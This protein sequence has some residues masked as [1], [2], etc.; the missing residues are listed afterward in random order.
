MIEKAKSIVLGVLVVLSLVQSYFLM[1][2]P[3]SLG[4]TVSSDQDYVNTEPMGK[5]LSVEDVIFPD[6]LVLHFGGNEHTVLYPG[7][8]FYEM[9]LNERIQGREFKGFQR[10]SA[11]VLDWDEIR[12]NDMGVEL[13]FEAG[14]SVELL[15][16][17]LKLK[18]DLLFLGDSIDR[19]LIFKTEDSEEVRT[20][21]FSV[22][23]ESVY[24]SVQADLTVRDVQDYVGFGQYQSRY[25]LTSD[26]LYVPE[27]PIRAVQMTYAYETFSP[28]LMRRNLFF[29]PSTTRAVEGRNGAQIYTDGKRGLQVEQSG[30]WISYTD[31]AAPQSAENVL[32]D[33]FYAAVEFVNQHGGWD[34]SYRYSSAA[35]GLD[36][37]VIQFQQYMNNY[38]VLTADSSR[39]GYMQLSL[40]QG[41]VTEYNRSL[42]TL[43]DEAEERTSRWLAGGT[44]LENALQSYDRREEVIALYPAVQA[45]KTEQKEGTRMSFVPVWAVRLA[46]GT[47]HTLL[48]AYPAGYTPPETETEQDEDGG[49]GTETG[50]LPPN[51]SY[52]AD[53]GGGGNNAG[54]NDT[55]DDLSSEVSGY[56]LG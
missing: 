22:D 21:F 35:S 2:S 48:E 17:L 15:Q 10:S 44:E 45:V 4:A 16:K 37:T 41:A 43:A 56:G 29:D 20:F 36:G 47:Q 23:G 7:S 3:P 38:P 32:S 1:Y 9:I 49:T 24:E 13:H 40:Q 55:N 19:V 52:G 5:E 12:K 6:E 39:Y 18:G 11:D 46:D 27:K 33:N 51:S 14:V 8:T 30:T 25:K 50:A 26:G 53:S 34:G 31:P 28:E 54:L 42:I